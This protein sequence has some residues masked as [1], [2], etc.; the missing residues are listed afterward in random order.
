MATFIVLENPKKWDLHVP[1]VE[2]IAAR[3][4]L[5]NLRFSDA[6]RAKVVN[7]CRT[8]GPKTLGYYVSLLAEARGHRPMPSVAT[9]QDLRLSPVVRI[10][11][12]EVE[13]LIQKSLGPPAAEPRVFRIYFG[14]SPSGDLDR[15]ARALFNYFPSPLLEVECVHSGRWRLESIRAIATNEIPDDERLFVPERAARHFRGRH[16]SAVATGAARYDLAILFDPA[17]VDAPSDERAIQKFVRA[18]ESLDMEASVIGREDFGDV[19]E[20][21]ALFIRQTTAVDHI[22]YRFARR[23]EA[24]GLVVIDAPQAIVRCTNKIYLAEVFERNGIPVPRTIVAH[25]DNLREIAAALG[26]PVVLKRPDS[27]FSQG[28]VKAHDDQE[29]E[30]L[31]VELL[32]SSEL[33]AAQ[34]FV[35]SSFDWRIG[36]LG[37][38]FLYGCKYHMAPGHWQIQRS[39][40]GS[41]RRFGAVEAVPRDAVPPAAIDLGVRSARLIGDGLFGV[42]IKEING[43][44]LV[45]EVNENPNIE[46]GYEDGVLGDEIYVAVMRWFLDRLERRGRGEPAR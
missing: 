33:V 34:E 32:D 21:D 10:V 26:F 1:G 11:S 2:V 46:V 18:A 36:V 43:R 41:W 30:K 5:T 39:G 7:M 24:E 20:Y 4:Y 22:T 27:S 25:E 28:V 37:G 44:F 40:A 35:P 3:E 29:L 13:D 31:M 17:A 12:A 23:A 38:E 15:L 45:M 6:R 19:A 8:Y 42:D 16:R 9:L 14:A